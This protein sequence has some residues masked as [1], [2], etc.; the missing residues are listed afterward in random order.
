MPDH[1]A[2]IVIE[3]GMGHIIVF[4]I[5]YD[6]GIRIVAPEYGIDVSPIGITAFRRAGGS[7]KQARHSESG[8][9]LSFHIHCGY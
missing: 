6:A 5:P 4:P 7:K 9:N 8:R 2:G 1:K 3:G